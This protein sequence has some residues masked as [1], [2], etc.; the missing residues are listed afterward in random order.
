MTISDKIKIIASDIQNCAEELIKLTI[1]KTLRPILNQV[2]SNNSIR[3]NNFL[4]KY[5]R[6]YMG[7]A[8]D[9]IINKYSYVLTRDCIGWT[10]NNVT[11]FKILAKFIKNKY[12]SSLPNNYGKIHTA[13]LVKRSKNESQTTI[14]KYTQSLS[15]YQNLINYLTAK[16]VQ[17]LVSNKAA[18]IYTYDMPYTDSVKQLESIGHDIINQTDPS[19][20]TKDASKL[21]TTALRSK[22]ASLEINLSH[23]LSLHPDIFGSYIKMVTLI[24]SLNRDKIIWF[25]NLISN[26]SYQNWDKLEESQKDIYIKMLGESFIVE[27]NANELVTILLQSD[28]SDLIIKASYLY[29][30]LKMLYIVFGYSE[31]KPIID[32]DNEKIPDCIPIDQCIYE[33]IRLFGD[34][35]PTIVSILGGTIVFP[36]E[37]YKI[38]C[39]EIPTNYDNLHNIPEFLL[40]F[41]YFSYCKYI[42]YFAEKQI[43]NALQTKIT[44]KT[45]ILKID[46]KF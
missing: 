9:D 1:R 12:P 15:S 45:K 46:K 14:N 13:L 43:G 36:P 29:S 28:N 5:E 20:S 25:I 11:N 40:R 35:Y 18:F 10:E 26:L 22:L 8:S 21:S 38:R 16:N 34:L 24:N 17:S 44:K 4:G 23:L 33:Y 39:N 41:Y 31:I 37:N 42:Q 27:L 19:I 7:S 30:L 2:Q 32:I 3:Y 6:G